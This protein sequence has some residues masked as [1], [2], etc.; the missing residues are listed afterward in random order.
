MIRWSQ[1]SFD[2]R[3]KRAT[4]RQSV[5]STNPTEGEQ[6]QCFL[7]SNKTTE[8]SPLLWEEKEPLWNQPPDTTDAGDELAAQ[9]TRNL[10]SL[11]YTTSF[12]KSEVGRQH[13][14]EG[15]GHKE[16]VAPEATCH[17]L[18]ATPL[19]YNLIFHEPFL[20]THL[21]SPQAA[22]I[23]TSKSPS[24]SKA[25]QNNNASSLQLNPHWNHKKL[26]QDLLAKT[27]Q[28]N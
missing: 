24:N 10:E 9:P 23:G 14:Q 22:T 3:S 19:S 16:H 5:L 13:H 1:T 8:S 2:S 21:P 26:G 11:G 17:Y 18:P 4:Q 15:L 27:K 7:N 25:D 6:E 12:K 28:C 20:G